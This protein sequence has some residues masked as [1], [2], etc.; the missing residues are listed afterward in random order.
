MANHPVGTQPSTQ[1]K[2]SVAAEFSSAHH[3]AE[4]LQRN[5]IGDSLLQSSLFSVVIS[6]R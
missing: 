5:G 6:W 4:L 3:G 2:T 1:L